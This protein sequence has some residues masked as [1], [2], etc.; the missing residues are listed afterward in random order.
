MCSETDGKF[1]MKINKIIESYR[2]ITDLNYYQ[3]LI[4]HKIRLYT[5]CRNKGWEHLP[6]F[7]QEERYDNTAIHPCPT[8][9]L[10]RSSLP[11]PGNATSRGVRDWIGSSD[12][13]TASLP[14]W[15][16]RGCSGV[17]LSACPLQNIV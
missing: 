15:E 10:P 8:H 9:P 6:L 13:G 14:C 11:I 1:Y 17:D 3:L 7:W 2:H 12:V 4:F 16:T 5:G